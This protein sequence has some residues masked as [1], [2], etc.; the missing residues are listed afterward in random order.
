MGALIFLWA[1]WGPAGC[2]LQ[3]GAGKDKAERV[4]TSTPELLFV[5]V[6]L[7]GFPDN[8]RFVIKRVLLRERRRRKKKISVNSWW[9]VG[10]LSGLKVAKCRFREFFSKVGVWFLVVCLVTLPVSS[11]VSESCCESCCVKSNAGCH[12]SAFPAPLAVGTEGA[13]ALVFEDTF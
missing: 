10:I 3:S 8:I 13:L 2:G 12:H 11:G 5:S 7:I 6:L 9:S 1:G 4:N